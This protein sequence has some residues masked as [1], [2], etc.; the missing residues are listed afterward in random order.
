M[1]VIRAAS[2]PI[3]SAGHGIPMGVTPAP[4]AMPGAANAARTVSTG[5]AVT[6]IRGFFRDPRHRVVGIIAAIVVIAMPK[7]GVIG[8]WS[9]QF[10]SSDEVQYYAASVQEKGT[11][12]VSM[13]VSGDDEYDSDSYQTQ[14][15]WRTTNTGYLVTLAGEA[16][17]VV[18][19]EPYRQ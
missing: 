5:N 19:P 1:N 17:E 10:V 7:R 6:G 9:V 18:V 12:S 16:Y 13:S 4:G 8:T 14:G 11:V 2:E 3:A 15:M